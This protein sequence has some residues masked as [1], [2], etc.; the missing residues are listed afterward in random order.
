MLGDHVAT[1]ESIP[2]PKDGAGALKIVISSDNQKKLQ[3]RIL[4]CRAITAGGYYI[5]VNDDTGLP[6]LASRSATSRAKIVAAKLYPEQAFGVP[7]QRR[8]GCDC[9]YVDQVSR[10]HGLADPTHRPADTRV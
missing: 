8:S 5:E 9:S 7:R 1:V 2:N 6:V 10:R 3:V 4:R